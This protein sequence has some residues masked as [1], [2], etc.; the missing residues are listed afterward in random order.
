[1]DIHQ[2]VTFKHVI[3]SGSFTKAA[4]ALFLTQPAV[5]HQIRSL[6]EELGQR[7][8]DR[9]RR[10]FRLTYAGE[11]FYEYVKRVLNLVEESKAALNDMKT[12]ER[13][14]VTVGAIGTTAVY[15]LPDFLYEFRMA[16]PNVQV[17]LL[18]VGGEEIKDMV[19]TNEVDLGI[20]GSHIATPELETIPL[21]EDQILPLVHPEHPCAVSG[22]VALADLAQEPFIQF[23]GWKSWKNY[24][25]SM[26]EEIGATPQ[27]LFQVDSIEAVKRLVERGLG[28]TIVPAV[29]AK[30]EITAGTLVPVYLTDIPPHSRKILLIYRKDKYLTAA[31]RV[32]IEAMVSKL[33]SVQSAG[34][35]KDSDE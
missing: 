34:V 27:E 13:G 7:L 6:E 17:V 19:M 28:F 21:F 24:V 33:G 25:L 18:T 35:G 31:I 22:R 4:A 11:V 9:D 20:V 8:L 16:R 26:F 1:M 14:R 5:S 10:P 30:E 2:L 29:A 15:V 3:E 12:G 23:G 32:F